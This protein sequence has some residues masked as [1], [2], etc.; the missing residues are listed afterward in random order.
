MASRMTEDIVEHIQ[1]SLVQ[2][3]HHNERIYL[4]QL[5]TDNPET[6]IPVIDNLARQNAYGK[7]FAKVPAPFWRTFETAGYEKEA[8]I[9]GFFRGKVDALFIAKYFTSERKTLQED[10]GVLD[11]ALQNTQKVSNSTSQVPSLTQNVDVCQPSDA[12]EMSSI[13]RQ[14][15]KSYPFPIQN[16]AFIERMMDAGNFYF[17]IR[18]QGKIAALAAAEIDLPH[19]AAEM[20]DFATLPQWRGRGFAGRFLRLMHRRIRDMGI[21]T[22]FTIARASSSG[23]NAVF[24]NCGYHYAGL[25]KN[26]SQICGGIQSMT[27]WYKHL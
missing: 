25:L 26:N 20:T 10:K 17:C 23:M 2:H 22:A 5:N 15:F 21:Q 18:V 13:Y 6:L 27:V 24:K 19:Q 16:P 12:A 8:V 14:V 11:Q 3:G 9:P 1:G 7:I 4:M